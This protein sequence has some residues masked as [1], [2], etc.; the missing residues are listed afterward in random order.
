MF[1]QLIAHLKPKSPIAE[2]YRMLRTNITFSSIDKDIKSIVVT[3]SAPSEGK[4]T[5]MANLAV[6]IAQTGKHVLLIDCD[7]RKPSVH[8][9]FGIMNLNGLTNVIAE[10]KD[11]RQC[12]QNVEV[13]NL[14]IMTSGPIPP[15]PSELLGSRRMDEFVKMVTKDYDMV[16]ID[17]PPVG[18]VTDAAILSTKVDGT[19]LVV[20]SGSTD[21]SLAQRAKQLL[22]KV[23]AN[24]I[25]VVLN[26]IS[27][28]TVG[29]YYYHYY[30]YYQ[31]E[32]PAPKR[33]KRKGRN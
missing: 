12:I 13:D 11:Y 21:I 15:N 23:Q 22:E 27:E 4:S 30:A 19:I 8:K 26:N 16:L 10:H 6:T 1:K 9:N 24:I 20:S 28:Q 32:D 33:K 7:L 17:A 5:T 25:G 18:A 29:S 31:H 3:S 14:D 2:A